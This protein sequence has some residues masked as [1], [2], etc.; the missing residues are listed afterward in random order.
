[1]RQ[2]SIS[3][4]AWALLGLLALLWG[5]SFLAN[6]L[7]LEDVGVLTTVAFRVTLGAALLW[8]FVAARRLPLPPWRRALPAFL[9]MGL[10]NNALPFTLIVWGQTRIESGLASILNAATAL[11]SVAVA[12]ALFADERL[13]ARK[14]LGLLTGFAGVVLAIGPA[15]LAAFDPR[16]TG[17][18]AVLG[19]ALSYAFAA[20]FARRM[21]AGIAP[22]VAAAGML[23][24]A[25]AL[26]L[27]AALWAEGVPGFDW[28]PASWAGLLYLAVVASALAYLLYYRI[29]AMAGAGNLGLVTLMLPPVA[30]VLGALVYGEALPLRAHAGFAVLATGLLLLDGR[31]G[32]RLRTESA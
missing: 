1:M 6:R 8:A 7:A 5:A 32:R 13:T 27:P 19:A 24:A 28:G 25:A 20:A 26:M 3:A 10:L 16:A 30:M 18:I 14:V 17:Q 12:A 21:L 11:F 15:H 23:T 22:E 4:R 29:L 9:G 31:I 2:T